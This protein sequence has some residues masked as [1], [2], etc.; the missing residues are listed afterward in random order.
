M[1]FSEMSMR[2]RKNASAAKI[3]RK[4]QRL[5]S[6][7]DKQNTSNIDFLHFSIPALYKCV[8]KTGIIGESTHK[9]HNL[10]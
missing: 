4:E 6:P 7:T 10:L 1:T 2:E 5:D 9:K 8:G 3:K